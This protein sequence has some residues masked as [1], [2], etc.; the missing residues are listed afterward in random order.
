MDRLEMVLFSKLNSMFFL[1]CCL[2][3]FMFVFIWGWPW[4][5]RLVWPSY[6]GR[7]ATTCVQ[8]LYVHLRFSIYA[9]IARLTNLHIM[10]DVQVPS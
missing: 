8:S 9:D 2:W 1:Y 7:C 4:K 5:Q 10:G 3:P 6:E